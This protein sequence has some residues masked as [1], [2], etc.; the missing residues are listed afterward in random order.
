MRC[1]SP[2]RDTRAVQAFRHGADGPGLRVKQ[3]R[4][5]SLRSAVRSTGAE[6]DA[7]NALASPSRARCLR[8]GQVASVAVERASH[9][10]EQLRNA[11]VGFMVEEPQ[12]AM[13]P[14]E[15]GWGGKLSCDGRQ[16][17]LLKKMERTCLSAKG[18]R[19][20]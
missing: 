15:L 8:A 13:A 19:K 10:Q 6:S 5:G 20:T 1:A 9:R 16:D 18:M 11:Y 14:H 7:K 4:V 2:L 12:H 17:L 3:T